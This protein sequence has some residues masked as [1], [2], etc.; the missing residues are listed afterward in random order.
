MRRRHFTAGF[1]TTLLAA[2]AFAPSAWAQGDDWPTRNVR[3]VCPFTP[4]GSQDNI[5]RRLARQAH[6]ASRPVLRRREPHRRRRLDRRRQRRQV[7]ARRLFGAAGQYRQ[8]RAGA[9]SLRQAAPT[10]PSPISRP[11][12]WIGTQPNLLCCHPELPA[13]HAAQAD[14]GG[15]GGARQVSATAPRASAPRRRSPW[16]CSSRRP[17]ST[18]PSSAIA[19]PPRPRPT[20]WPATCRWCIANIDSLMGQVSAG[21]LK[22]IATT[23]ATALAVPPDTPTFVEAGFPDLDRHLVVAL[24]GADGHAG[25]DQGEAQAR[26]PRRP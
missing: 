18:S 2:P 20:C 15:Q 23:G 6:R 22:P 12:C 14:R 5:A 19:A 1:G 11:W 25:D 26:A 9:A 4:G 7:A 16:S 3:I 10:T 13:R 17:A 24:G 21:K 8:P